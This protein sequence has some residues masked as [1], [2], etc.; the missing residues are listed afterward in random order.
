[1]K[2]NK[3]YYNLFSMK[4]IFLLLCFL[5]GIMCSNIQAQTYVIK[6]V[7]Y[8]IPEAIDL[9]LPS[10]VKWANMNMGASSVNEIGGYYGWADPTGE[11]TVDDYFWRCTT[12]DGAWTSPLFGGT[13]P[14][15]DISGTNLDIATT[16]L[17]VEWCMPSSNDFKELTNNCSFSVENDY[18]RVIGPN[19]NSII[20]PISGMWIWSHQ[21]GG[22]DASRWKYMQEMTSY[23]CFW[24]STRSFYNHE[25]SDYWSQY[26]QPAADYAHADK[27]GFLGVSG[28]CDSWYRNGMIPIRAIKRDN[29]NKCVPPTITFLPN[30]K[31]KV[32]SATEGA[33]CVTNITASNAEPLSD[34]EIS[35]NTPLIV[36]TVTSYATKE[37]YYDSEVTTATFRYEKTEGDMN[38]DGMLNITDVIHL[39]NMILGQ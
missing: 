17:G 6:G 14:P 15:R 26:N 30:G 27:E 18:V 23:P 13:N 16:R 24:A 33:A 28:T 37:G 10:G 8:P 2:S 35:L 11:L 3:C 25:D 29:P 12:L 31:I 36:Y 39:V 4:K 22:T 20:L 34:G 38:G 9:G 7:T 5:F 21:G 19:G 1:M 32:E